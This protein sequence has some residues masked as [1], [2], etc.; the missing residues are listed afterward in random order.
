[1]R[2]KNLL[3]LQNEFM[4]L[5]DFLHADSDVDCH[6]QYLWLLN[7]ILLQLYLLDPW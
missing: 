3:Y 4:N 6:A 2:P 5:A 7:V 1:M